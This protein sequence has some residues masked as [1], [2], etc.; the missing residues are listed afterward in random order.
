MMKNIK[1]LPR[2]SE[3]GSHNYAF[4]DRIFYDQVGKTLPVLEVVM[5]TMQAQA[6]LYPY[7]LL[8]DE[9]DDASWIA[10]NETIAGQIALSEPLLCSVFFTSRLL[11]KTLCQILA[12]RL[13]RK[14]DDKYYVLRYYDPRVISHLLWMFSDEEWRAFELETRCSSWTIYLNGGWHSFE[15]ETNEDDVRDCTVRN[16][17]ETLLNIGDINSVFSVLPKEAHLKDHIH[18]SQKVNGYL[19]TAKDQY[20]FVNPLDRIAFAH[21]CVTVGEGFD[22]T[23]FMAKAISNGKQNNMRY[24]TF[25]GNFSPPDWLLIN[26]QLAHEH[27]KEKM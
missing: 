17:K 4:I 12:E 24:T 3:L 1:L 6:H 5:P 15:I 21:H 14:Y 23:P 9:L 16:S 13:I 18:L 25:T 19:V 8:L 7:L 26:D 20:G 27:T 2:P 22:E 11:P 10:L